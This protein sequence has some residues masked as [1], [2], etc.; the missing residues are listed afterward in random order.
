LGNG[1]V[2]LL[3]NNKPATY[4]KAMIDPNFEIWQVAMRTEID[5]MGDNQVWN[6][7]DPPNGVRPIECK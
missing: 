7:V 3:D 6:L 2:L 1:E 5:S 4:V